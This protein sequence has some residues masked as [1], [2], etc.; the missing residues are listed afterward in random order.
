M[1]SSTQSPGQA[2]K[3]PGGGNSSNNAVL[4]SNGSGEIVQ[5]VMRNVTPGECHPHPSTGAALLEGKS[6]LAWI[7]YDNGASISLWVRSDHLDIKVREF[8]LV[9]G[10]TGTFYAPI[11]ECEVSSAIFIGNA[12]VGVVDSLPLDVEQL[13]NND[14][15]MGD[16]VDVPLLTKL[17]VNEDVHHVIDNVNVY[18]SC[19]MTRSMAQERLGDDPRWSRPMLPSLLQFKQLMLLG[20]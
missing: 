19:A 9:E 15:V 2:R 18:P 8:V 1:G 12:Q 6:Y 20:W 13:I 3:V 5:D 7:L 4:E 16:S 14:L 11:I 17:P 10:V